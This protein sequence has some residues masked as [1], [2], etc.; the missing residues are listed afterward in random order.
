MCFSVCAKIA[1]FGSKIDVFFWLIL[2]F[3]VNY[4]LFLSHV[5]SSLRVTRDGI[6]HFLSAESGSPIKI[7]FLVC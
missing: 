5:S 2:L 1:T 7:S 6:K 4:L 3:K